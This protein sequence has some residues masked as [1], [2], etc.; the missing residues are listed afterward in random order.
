MKRL[1]REH[2][3]DVLMVCGAAALCYGAWL[4]WPPAGWMLLGAAITLAGLAAA[5]GA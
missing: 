4:A 3:P 5:G 2:V 1:I